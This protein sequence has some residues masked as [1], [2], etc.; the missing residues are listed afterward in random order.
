MS[1]RYSL[2]IDPDC[3]HTGWG[4]VQQ[5]NDL[6]PTLYAAGVVSIPGQIKKRKIK[7][8]E[9]VILMATTLYLMELPMVEYSAIVVEGQ[10]IYRR[11]SHDKG[12]DPNAILRI[13]QVSGAA[14]VAALAGTEGPTQVFL[15]EPKTWKKQVPKRIHQARVC[16][17]LGYGYKAHGTAKDGYVVPLLP[18]GSP[19]ARKCAELKP[20]HWKHA[21]DGVG[22]ALYGLDQLA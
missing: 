14:L 6:P 5:V 4:I 3:R 19:A 17:R 7:G 21:M 9:A 13:G 16:K 12:V 20:T 10:T 15:P 2:G 8:N 22:L 1:V 11:G 18:Q